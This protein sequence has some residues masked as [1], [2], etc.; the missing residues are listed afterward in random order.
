L[1]EEEFLVLLDNFGDKLQTKGVATAIDK[2][3]ESL[4]NNTPQREV[5]T[6]W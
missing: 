4:G 3:K 2:D 6:E 5:R 1:P